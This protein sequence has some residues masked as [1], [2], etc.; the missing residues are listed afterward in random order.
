M[1]GVT[2]NCVRI[3]TKTFSLAWMSDNA[4]FMTLLNLSH[5]AFLTSRWRFILLNSLIPV[6]R[7]TTV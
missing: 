6:Y 7:Q 2:S 1:Y 5:E 4:F 3:A